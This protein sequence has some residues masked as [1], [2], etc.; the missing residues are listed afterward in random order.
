[1]PD[2]E[3]HEVR[4]DSRPAARQDSGAILVY[5]A[6]LIPV[7]LGVAAIA[8]DVSRWYVETQRVQKTVDAAAL[9]AAPYM[10]DSL[11]ASPETPAVKAARDLVDANGYPRTSPVVAAGPRPTTVKVSLTTSVRN[12]FGTF[13]GKGTQSITRS[14]VAEFVGPAPLGSPCNVHGNEPR[15]SSEGSRL[16]SPLPANCT[17]YPQFW[18]TIVGPEVF[19]TQ[20]DEYASRKCGVD[21]YQESD[22]LTPG[23]G[24][25]NALFDP[26]G[27]NGYEGKDGYAIT[28]RLRQ[29]LA[30]PVTIQVY[31]PAYVDTGSDCSELPN[32]TTNTLGSNTYSTNSVE[33]YESNAS[34]LSGGRPSFCSGDN[35]NSGLR[36]PTSSDTSYSG[37]TATVTSFGLLSPTDTLNPF[38]PTV[39]AN[40][41][42]A[43][44]TQQFGGFSKNGSGTGTWASPQYTV[45][46]S[47]A[48]AQLSANN[49]LTQFFHQ[50]VTL[51]QI[52]AGSAA[53]D[54]YLRVRTNVPWGSATSVFGAGDSAS[55]TGN[56][57]NRFAVRAYTASASDADKISVS[58]YARMPI[59]AN[60]TNATTVFNLV[61]VLPE[62]AGANIIFTF[63]DVGD[64]TSST[65]GYGTLTVLPP[66][67]AVL[68]TYPGGTAFDTATGCTK[69]GFLVN[70]TPGTCAVS[71]IRNSDGWNGQREQITIP[72][73]SSYDCNDASPFG[74]WWRLQVR[75]TNTTAVTDQTT[76]TAQLDGDP[77]RLVR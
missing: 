70:A 55:V 73:P 36:F 20:G 39:N 16:P 28:I 31:D 38:D 22:C 53:G 69:S 9:A 60:T 56:G 13:F 7:L 62:S 14:A 25:A 33:R 66:D 18:S 42:V 6:L 44:C 4:P 1:M 75:F 77:V 63:F 57:S 30:S 12:V 40:N 46:G 35:D 2:P 61:R 72:V 19:K 43:G 8:V 47:S 23:V 51:C 3:V 26:S 21:P 50:W 32:I 71:G 68:G 10:P 58:P 52:P 64:A 17:N 27:N 29:S 37:E 24:G 59:F 41:R 76:W 65:G 34:G 54:Y 45:A 67:E 15:T 11:T 74:C 49:S 5:V 48:T